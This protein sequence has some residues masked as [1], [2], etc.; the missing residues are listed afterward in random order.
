MIKFHQNTKVWRIF[1][2]DHLLLEKKSEYY[3]VL[4][5]IHFAKFGQLIQEIDGKKNDSKK[6]FFFREKCFLAW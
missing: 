5:K 3:K 1:F 2:G 4:H 6:I